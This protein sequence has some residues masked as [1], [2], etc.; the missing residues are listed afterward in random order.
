MTFMGETVNDPPK[1]GAG[2]GG[3]RLADMLLFG[4]YDGE[5]PDTTDTEQPGK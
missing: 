4:E 1:D 3:R 5:G 2:N